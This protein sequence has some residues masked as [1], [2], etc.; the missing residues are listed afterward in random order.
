MPELD[1]AASLTP[2]NAEAQ[3][4]LGEAYLNLNQDEKAM[5]SF[6]EAT[7]ISASAGIW[8][9]IAYQL[10]L[11][12]VHPDLPRRY[13]ESAV[14][15]TAAVLRNVTLDQPSKHDLTLVSS[16]AAYWDT[17]G[18]VEFVTGHP[19]KAL[20][21]CLAGWQAGQRANIADHL[22]QIYEK[23]GNKKDAIRFYALSLNAR[24]PDPE[25]R[26]RLG[27][28]AG[29]DDEVN[30]LIAKYRDEL[31]QSLYVKVANTTK[32]YG[33]ADFLLLLSGGSGGESST[34]NTKFVSGKDNMKDFTDVRKARYTQEIPDD[35]PVKLLRRG[36]LTCSEGSSE[37][38]LQLALPE[39]VKS[40]D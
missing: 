12:K 18:W 8:N 4:R 5:Q 14:T 38:T 20:K 17:L 15:T 25:T 11:K 35:T 40:A 24:R 33:K 39:D 16:I 32:Q 7:R 36:T 28:L 34:E 13:A 31:P 10:A 27:A 30:A 19:D 23:Q 9:G 21:Y 1:R 26:S 37:C 22:G 29:G 6:D 2:N 3:V